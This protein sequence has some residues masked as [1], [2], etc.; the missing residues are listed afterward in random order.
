MVRL[1]F[2]D[3]FDQQLP[4][5]LWTVGS[6]QL[7]GCLEMQGIPIWLNAK[8]KLV[9]NEPSNEVEHAALRTFVYKGH[10]RKAVNKE[11]TAHFRQN[12]GIWGG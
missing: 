6:I 10:D 2:F 7:S 3:D 4:D 11:Y 12:F 8:S 5:I 1:E 9:I